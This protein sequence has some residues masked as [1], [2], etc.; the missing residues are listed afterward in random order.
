MFRQLQDN[1]GRV[2]PLSRTVL[3][4]EGGTGVT[5]K[6]E[7]V[8]ALQAISRDKI[9]APLGIAGTDATGRLFKKYFEHIEIE[10]THHLLGKKTIAVNKTVSYSISNFNMFDEEFNIALSGVSYEDFVIHQGNFSFK[11]TSLGVLRITIGGRSFDI[12]VVNE[13]IQKP[14]ITYPKQNA[15]VPRSSSFSV[16]EIKT[17]SETTGNETAVFAGESLATFPTHAIGIEFAGRAG[18]YKIGSTTHNGYAKMV[19][20]ERSYDLGQATTI[21]RIDRKRAQYARF[22]VSPGSE[23]GFRFI[24]PAVTH[25]KTKWEISTTSDFASP[26][27]VLESVAPS[28]NGLVQTLAVGTYF[29]RAKHISDT[30]ESA[31]SDPVSFTVSTEHDLFNDKKEFSSDTIASSQKFGSALSF[32]EDSQV[33]AVGAPGNSDKFTNAGVV[34]LYKRNGLNFDYLDRIY[35]PDDRAND[36]F[37]SSVSFS[38]SGEHLAIGAPGRYALVGGANV[39][40]AVFIYKKTD[41]GYRHIQTIMAPS[42]SVEFGYAV[43][44][45][46]SRLFISDP[47]THA[48]GTHRGKVYQYRFI[49]N[50]ATFEKEITANI[51]L[52]QGYFGCALETDEQ[53]EFLFIGAE[54]HENSTDRQGKIHIFKLN[55][56]T[57]VHH[58]T[59]TPTGTTSPLGFGRSLSY[60]SIGRC[61]VVGAPLNPGQGEKAGSFY[62]MNWDGDTLS[63]R[64]VVYKTTGDSSDLF[65]NSVVVSKNGLEVFAGSPNGYIGSIR[66]GFVSLYI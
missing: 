7:A 54:A 25:T 30:L 34:Y 24:Y 48:G 50:E 23:C 11:P 37:G 15:S 28:I 66:N 12:Q 31:W 14:V 43:K 59:I 47:S 13:A 52:N 6:D 26:L 20:G 51:P 49:S 32:H 8:E 4:S 45:T 62:V 1:F 65:G 41:K 16:S 39:Y 33:L 57:Y 56:D 10:K 42:Q 17:I 38:P 27:H 9:D 18:Q 36:R 29:I 35:C 61:V 5:T 21:I 60:A 22:I 53:H 40:G 64:E 44:L 46:N 55:N 3:L 2:K 58:K 19:V 63:H